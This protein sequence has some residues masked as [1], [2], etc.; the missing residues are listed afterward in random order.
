MVFT[1]LFCHPCYTGLN[2]AAGTNGMKNTICV[3]YEDRQEMKNK[4]SAYAVCAD[5][6]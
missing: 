3:R 2:I 4:R 6:N 1:T 5:N